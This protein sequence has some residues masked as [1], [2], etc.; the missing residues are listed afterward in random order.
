MKHIV[1]VDPAS[2][3]GWREPDYVMFILYV[4]Y[5]LDY[6]KTVVF[7]ASKLQDVLVDFRSVFHV[8][9]IGQ[10]FDNALASGNGGSRCK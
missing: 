5:L 9:Q 8:G 4:R 1:N 2:N 6:L 7:S 10:R 3:L